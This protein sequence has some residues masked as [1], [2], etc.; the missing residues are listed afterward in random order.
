MVSED[1]DNFYWI[2]LNQDPKMLEVVVIKPAAVLKS[3]LRVMTD[4]NKMQNYHMDSD[5]LWTTLN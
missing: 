2:L 4:F 3:D 1:L 5:N